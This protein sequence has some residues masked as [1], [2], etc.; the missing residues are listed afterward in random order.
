MGEETTQEKSRGITR[1]IVKQL[2][3]GDRVWMKT[4]SD[5]AIFTGST[6]PFRF[7]GFELV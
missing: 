2:D 4:I 3:A 6:T 7:M 1:M 5:G